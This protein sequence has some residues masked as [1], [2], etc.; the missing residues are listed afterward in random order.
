[1]RRN[2]KWLVI[3][4]T[5]VVAAAFLTAYKF[6][7]ETTGTKFERHLSAL[8]KDCKAR[9]PASNDTRCDLLKVKVD[10]PLSTPEGRFAHA[11]QIPNP[12]P[13]DSGYR[14]WMTR[15]QYFEHLCKHEAGE[16]IFKTVDNVEGI[17]QMRARE[18][19]NEYKLQHL[20]ALEDP[21]GYSHLANPPSEFLEKDQYSYFEY[22]AHQYRWN[23][24]IKPFYDSSVFE[25]GKP[26]DKIE[27]Y[28]GD[29][30]EFRNLKKEF[31][32]QPKSRYGYTWR[33]I[34]RPHDRE[35]GIAGGELIALDLQTNEVLGVR[36]G[37]AFYRGSWELT[38][39]C[40][41]YGYEGGFDKGFRFQFWF[42][43]KVLRP[44][45]W[46]ERFYRL[47]ET[48]IPRK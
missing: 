19:V 8:A 10:D 1:M 27:H 12:L 33:G 17:Y 38:P 21:Y 13:E 9:P 11:I 30:R 15:V 23:P 40:P 22:P 31:A 28:S 4:G 35:M 2:I 34:R 36:R 24:D 39:V 18:Q 29:L 20:Y 5:A 7:F 41:K 45:G 48:R 47:E 3:I 42:L 43:G 16:F 46:K 37:Y 25:P 26:E 6:L 44:P 14:W 32:V